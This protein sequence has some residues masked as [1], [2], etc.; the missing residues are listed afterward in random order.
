MKISFIILIAFACF[1]GL[2]AFSTYPSG[3]LRFE[4]VSANGKAINA[5]IYKI[6]QDPYGF[7]WLGTDY[8]LLRYDGYRTIRVESGHPENS[9]LLGT[10]GTEAL[11]LAK[12]TSLWIGTN[13]GVF[14]LCL[15]SWDIKRPDKFAN[16][17]VRAILYQNDSIVWI[18]T[19]EGLYKYN[20]HTDGSVFYNQLNSNLS[21]NIILA[22]YLDTSGNLWVG[23]EDKLNILYSGR[24]QFESVDLKRSYKPNIK[25]NLVLDI[26]PYSDGSDSILFVGTE[27]GLFMVNR[28]TNEIRT[29]NMT[30]SDLSNEVVKTIYARNRE[31]I[32]FGTDL[33]FN[34]LNPLTG[35]VEKYYHNPFDQYSVINNQIWNILPDNKGNLWLATSNGISRLNLSAELFKYYPV[36]FGVKDEPVGTRVA[37]VLYDSSHTYWIATSNGL[38][39]AGD[40]KDSDH[41]FMSVMDNTPL[42]SENLNAISIDSSNRVWIGSVA[43]INIW[44][45]RRKKVFIPFM[46]D[47]AG[48]RVSSNYIS[49]IIKGYNNVF[50]IGTWGGGLY[51]ANTGIQELEEIEIHYAAD[52]NGLMVKGKDHLWAL[53]RNSLIKFSFNTEKVEVIDGLNRISGN[54]VLTAIAYSKGE[55]IWIGSKNQLFKYDIHEDLFEAIQMPIDEDFIVTGIIED[56]D[57]II[58]GSS[59]HTIFRFDPTARVFNYFPIPDRTPLKKL[60]LS[61]FRKT[62]GGDIL[63]CGFDGFLKFSPRDFYR[64][65]KNRMVLITAV[66]VNGKPVF[67]NMELSGKNI[68]TSTISNSRELELPYKSRNIKLEYSSFPYG[69]MGQEQ[70]ACMLDGFESFWRVNESGS[71]SIDYINLPPGNYIFRVKSLSGDSNNPVTSLNIKIRLPFWASPPLFATYIILLLLVIGVMVYQYRNRLKDRAEMNLIRLEKD[72]NELRS[73]SKIR[74]YINISHELLTSISLIIDPIKTILARKEIKDDT[75]KTLKLVERNA[76][77]L[78]VYIDQ[79]LNF[80]K[81]EMGYK[82]D[83]LNDNLELIAFCREVIESFKGKAIS[84]GVSLKLKAEIKEVTIETDEEKLYSIIQ[85]LLSNAINFTPGG[86]GVVLSIKPG[87]DRRI[88]IEVKD[89]GIGI[90]PEDQQKVFDRFYQV[91]GGNIPQRGMGIGLTI[92]KDFVEVLNGKIDLESEIGVGTKVRITL[93]SGNEFSV[94]A[95][96]EIFVREF[97]NKETIQK[98]REASG[99]QE[100]MASGL[101]VVLVVDEN[102]DLYEYISTSLA[103]RYSILWASSGNDA[104]GMIREGIPTVLVSEIQLPDMNGISFAQQVRKKIKTN[105][106]PM[107]FLSSKIEKESQLKAIEAGVDLFLAKPFEIEILEANIAN[108]IAGREKTEQLI[109]R[110]LLI[111]AHQ[112]EVDSKDDKLLKEVVEYIHRNMTNSRITANEI[113]YAVGISHSNLYRRI[114]SLTDQSLNE[115]IRFIRLQKAEQLLASGKLSVSEVMFQVGFTN[116]SYFSKCFRKLYHVTPKNYAKK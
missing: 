5:R 82:R 14:N 91:P 38:L 37:D 26:Q 35:S 3:M 4:T 79:M 27:T 95:Q 13:M 90:S 108:L 89:N 113:S 114:K 61:P 7:I 98:V 78:K 59:D 68:L 1:R 74:F 12:D 53:N 54:S 50:W 93:P 19:N 69:D 67:P 49:T 85:N 102:I 83:R 11:S 9:A 33:G 94:R 87:P 81:I 100:G 46:D 65:E 34:M 6:V 84:K 25:H 71:N 39:S 48:S 99:I 36:F 62:S 112:V 80:R 116:H 52:F 57:G 18:G 17:I 44:D 31:E 63:V 29:F 75:R 66:K 101:P 72:Q 76:H 42:S 109:N 28:L 45:S 30:T 110:K 22:I 115:F 77:F 104:L 96:D 88:I 92:V 64:I 43:G 105:R 106:I 70:Y 8:G 86:G 21:Q 60:I 97:V 16:H 111:S 15:K 58:W 2:Y 107:I 103:G 41:T 40:Q 73:L 20:P 24:E 10:A 32:Y 51:R 56:E 55:A 47:G 23:T